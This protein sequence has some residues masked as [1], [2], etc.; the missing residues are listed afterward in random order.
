MFNQ[1]TVG[2][3]RVIAKKGDPEKRTIAS[4]SSVM[5]FTAVPLTKQ[6]E[7]PIWY[8][9]TLWGGL[10]DL[11][12]G[13]IKHSDVFLIA[14]EVGRT[15][16]GDEDDPKYDD[17]LTVRSIQRVQPLPLKVYTKGENSSEAEAQAEKM[18]S[19]ANN[20]KSSKKDLPF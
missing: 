11:L 3:F 8:K 12:E 20:G 4:G 2:L 18:A 7:E 6:D 19:A 17:T 5:N 16:W 14:G 13:D 1:T 9:V 10:A 15:K